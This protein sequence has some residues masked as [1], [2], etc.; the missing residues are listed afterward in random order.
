MSLL[1]QAM[2]PAVLNAAWNRLKVEHTPWT[3]AIGRRQLQRDLMQHLL[4]CREEVLAGRYRPEP[5]RCFHVAKTDGSQRPLVAQYLRDKLVQRALL[6]VLTPR[7]EALFHPDSYAYR[8]GRGVN[9]ALAAAHQRIQQGQGWLVDADVSQF[10]ETIPLAQLRRKLQAFIRDAGA[11]RLIDQWL[12]QGS[13]TTG[14]L[15]TARGIPQ[16]AVLSPLFCNLYMH[17]FDNAL[18]QQ[19]IAFVRFADDFLLFA[20]NQVNANRYLDY[21]QHKL[22]RMGLALNPAKTRVT[23]SSPDTIFLGK[24]LLEAK[25]SV[26]HKHRSSPFNLIPSFFNL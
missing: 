1:A 16:G 21:A 15:G 12:Q 26:S 10:F 17:E 14:L 6:A 5:L 8:P 4:T 2:E 7:A 13:Q 18:A 3:E 22:T 25:P 9:K 19:G 20:D 11:L 24:P 23:L